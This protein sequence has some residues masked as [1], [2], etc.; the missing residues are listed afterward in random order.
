M[1]GGLA[2]PIYVLHGLVL[3]LRNVLAAAGLPGVV[4]LALPMGAFL[5]SMGYAGR[6]LWRMYFG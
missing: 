2:L 4:A 6:R 3:P 5:A 1:T